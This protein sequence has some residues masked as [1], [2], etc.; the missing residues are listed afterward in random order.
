MRRFAITLVVF[1]FSVAWA[2]AA[3]LEIK[4]VTSVGPY[5]LVKLSAANVPPK[6]GVLWKVTPIGNDPKNPVTIDWASRKNAHE[7]AWVAPP[8]AYTVTLMAG[9]QGEGGEFTLDAAEATVVITSP[10]PTPPQPPGPGPNPPGP[11]PD[12]TAPFAGLQGLRV[13]VVYESGDLSKLSIAQQGAIYAKSVRDY[14]NQK[15]PA[16]PDGKTREWRMY[17]TDVDL[18][19]ESK[20]WQDAMKLPRTGLPWVY[21]GNGTAGYSGPL[22]ASAD[23]MLALLRKFGGN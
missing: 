20:T 9:G 23:D 6:A 19:G 13:L 12:K 21:V 4:G 3:D 16:G 14:L 8:G 10:E 17:D 15:C 7:I 18:T 22:P 11:T 2:A 1:T 5:R